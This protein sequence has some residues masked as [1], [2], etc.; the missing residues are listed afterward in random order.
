MLDVG[1]GDGMVIR[2]K[3][4]RIYLSDFGSSSVKGVGTYRLLPFLRVKGYGRIEGI[5][6]SHLDMDHY[7]GVLELLEAA[8]EE[9]ISIGTLFLPISVREEGTA[10]KLAEL[11]ELAELT[12]VSV[13][14]LQAGDRVIDG[15]TE[16][17]C[18]HPGNGEYESNNGSMVVSVEYGDFSFLLTGDVEKEGE[19]EIRERIDQLGQY[20]LLKVAHHGSKGSSMEAFLEEIQPRVSLISC[21]EN[22]RYGHP[23][24]EVLD[25]LAKAGSLVLQTPETGAIT[26]RPKEDGSFTVETFLTGEGE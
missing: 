12:D 21:G 22:N 23:A 14:F 2:T 19:E 10:E 3:S 18:L 20:H 4:G 17:F 15:K 13:A 7:N 9:H 26:I 24:G 11:L 8:E 1:Q 16:F 5:F 6:V 25:R